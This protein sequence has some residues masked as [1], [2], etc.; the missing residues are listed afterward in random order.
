MP[1]F[2]AAD[3]AFFR[4]NGYVIARD[5]VPAKNLRAAV[6]MIWD[7]LGMDPTDPSDWYRPPLS[8]GGMLEVYQHS[9]CG[10]TGRPR[11]STRR[12]PNCSALKSSGPASTA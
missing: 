12:S 3:H 11:A 6:A 4:E 1:V 10:T 2:T 7:F 9:R 5:V 8:P